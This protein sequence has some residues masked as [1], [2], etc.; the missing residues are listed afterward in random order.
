MFHF[1]F[2]LRKSVKTALFKLGD[3]L[4]H[5]EEEGIGETDAEASE[6]EKP[7][8]A[9]EEAGEEGIEG[10]EADIGGAQMGEAEGEVSEEEEGG[11]EESKPVEDGE[12]TEASQKEGEDEGPG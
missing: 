3:E 9:S 5:E 7:E 11:A 1:F 6:A 2:K 12:V 8:D 10:G 4:E